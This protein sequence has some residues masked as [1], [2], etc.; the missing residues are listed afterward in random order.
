MFAKAC[1]LVAILLLASAAGPVGFAAS[2]ASKP[3]PSALYVI[4]GTDQTT[5]AIIASWGLREIGP[6]RAPFARLIHAPAEVH[7][8]LVEN[9]YLIFPAT[10]LAELCGIQL[11]V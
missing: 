3:D 5:S 2:H 6:Y 4:V 11:A 10:P 7:A 1:T 9:A 8:S